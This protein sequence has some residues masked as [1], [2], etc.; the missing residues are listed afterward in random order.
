MSTDFPTPDREEAQARFRPLRFQFAA[1]GRAPS[2]LPVATL[3]MIGLCVGVFLLQTLA[4]GSQNSD[5]LMDFGASYRPYFEQGQYWRAVM[6]MFLHIGWWHLA[7]NMYVLYMLGPLLEKIYGYGRYAFIYV[8]AGVSSSLLTMFHGHSVAAGASGAIMGVAGA[9][10]SASYLH[11]SQLPYPLARIFHRTKF[12][13]T[14]LIFVALTLASGYLTSNIDNWGHIG[15]LV[16]GAILGALMTPP[17]APSSAG[18][19]GVEPAENPSQAIVL[20][21]V[22]VVALAMAVTARHYRVAHQVT[23]L[24]EEAIRLDAAHQPQGAFDRFKR[25][26]Q[27]DPQDERAHYGLGELDL[28]NHRPGEAIDE[29]RRA[30]RISPDSIQAE[31]GLAEAY[32]EIGDHARAEKAYDA[33]L[34]GHPGDPG[35]HEAAARFFTTQKLYQPAIDQYQQ[36]LRLS[37]NNALAHNNLAWLYATAE[38][39]KFR[40]PAAALEHA[41]KA[42]N[43]TGSRDPDLTDTLAEALYVNGKFADA[44]NVEGKTLQLA[45]DNKDFQ[46]HMRRYQKAAQN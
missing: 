39:P 15:G 45:P 24:L 22:I 12:T 14:V 3:V 20:V 21:P 11:R 28:E 19:M 2:S 30:L 43:L 33:L 40:N 16:S 6:P 29:F 10:V 13:F 44:V 31:A 7:M 4:G 17:L 9:L 38:N 27:V 26:E 35:A 46:E 41:T 8:A 32:E 23:K 34:R 18:V 37:P 42:V 1:Q 25:A 5:V 36:V